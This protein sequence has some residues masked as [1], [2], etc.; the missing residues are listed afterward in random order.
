[1][2]AYIYRVKIQS[3]SPR[4]W[5]QQRRD[6]RT[7]VSMHVTGD[8]DRRAGFPIAPTIAVVISIAVPQQVQTCARPDLHQRQWPALC[9]VGDTCKRR[10]QTRGPLHLVGL[11]ETRRDQVADLGAVLQAERS[12]N[13]IRVFAPAHRPGKSCTRDAW[14]ER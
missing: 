12:E 11:D 10:N 14:V 8:A 5:W 4:N 9:L 7:P 13:G 2:F 3:H 6:R 1:R